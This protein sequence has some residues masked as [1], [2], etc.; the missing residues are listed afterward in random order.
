MLFAEGDYFGITCEAREHTAVF[1][2][3]NRVFEEI[4]RDSATGDVC[5][6]LREAESDNMEQWVQD[7]IATGEYDFLRDDQNQPQDD[8]LNDDEALFFNFDD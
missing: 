6:L 1:S 3:P 5:M 8:Q 2:I 4:W 7:L